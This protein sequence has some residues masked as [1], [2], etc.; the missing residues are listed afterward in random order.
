MTRRSTHAI[1]VHGDVVIKTYRSWKRDEPGR[2]WRALQLLTVYA[3]GLAPA[4]MRAN[5]RADAPMVVM[6]RLPGVALEATASTPQQLKSLAE[7]IVTLH[8]AIPP[9]VAADLPPRLWHL[10][11]TVARV[12]DQCARRPPLGP[13]PMVAEAFTAAARWVTGPHLD[14]LVE[15]KVRPVLGHG[16]GNLANLIWDADTGRVRLVDFEDSGR[17]DAAMEIA[18]LVEHISAWTESEL[19]V[20]CLLEFCHLSQQE[21]ARLQV[22]RRLLAL[23]WLL[24]LR[25]GTASAAR[26]P[27]TTLR[28]QA[29]RL[30]ALLG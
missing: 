12:R 15:E 23:W 29:E 20:T 1:D 9:Q 8:R 6:S 27:P 13:D 10:A 30:L 4:P 24:A 11:E 25:P 5:L 19:D 28:R 7:A 3:P 26:N 18:D 21:A 16:D 22:L 17:S 14:R 2:E